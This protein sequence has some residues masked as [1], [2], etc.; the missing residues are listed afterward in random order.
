MNRSTVSPPTEKL[1]NNGWEV[2]GNAGRPEP[3][4]PRIL[5]DPGPW[6]FTRL[7]CSCVWACM[8]IHDGTLLMTSFLGEC[9]ACPGSVQR[10]RST[11]SHRFP[12]LYAVY[13]SHSTFWILQSN[14]KVSLLAFTELLK[15]ASLTFVPYAPKPSKQP[16]RS[17]GKHPFKSI[18]KQSNSLNKNLQINSS[19]T[20]VQMPLVSREVL[21]DD[22]WWQEAARDSEAIVQD[23]QASGDDLDRPRGMCSDSF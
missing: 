22:D 1:T 17:I 6:A 18:L 21:G 14:L 7:V 4:L 11:R 19:N 10:S 23:I 15:M 13:N 3:S 12:P 8:K 2:L 5:Q 16:S 20:P 9:G